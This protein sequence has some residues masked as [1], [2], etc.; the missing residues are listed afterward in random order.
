MRLCSLFAF[1]A[2][3]SIGVA[4]VNTGGILGSVT[5]PSGA[6]VQGVT[7][8][9]T[10]LGTQALR[11]TTTGSDG[12]YDVQLLQVGSYSISAEAQGFKKIVQTGI[13][14]DAGQRLKIDLVLEVGALA[15][16]VAVSGTAPLVNS[17]TSETG[18]VIKNQQVLD[19]PLNGRN[20]SQLIQLEPG[21][22]VTSD[23]RISFS[24]LT[25]DGANITIDGTDAASPDRPSTSDF[26]GQSQQN[27]LS[28]EFIDEFKTTKG[29]FSAELGRAIGGGVNV[30]TKSGTNNF[31]GSLF[32]FLRNQKFDARN[33]FA[34]TKDPLKINQFGMALGGP[35]IRNKLFLFA[36][37][38]APR[39]RRGTQITGNVPTELLR[40]QMLAS[41]PAYKALLDLEPLPNVAG[42]GNT[43]I[44]L[45]R[46]SGLF[47]NDEI[48][49][50][51]RADYHLSTAD[52]FF[53]RYSFLNSSAS[54]PSISPQNPT[55]YPSQDQSGT[56]S[57]AHLFG[58]S[59]FNELRLGWN[60]Q[61]IP[62][63]EAAFTGPQDIGRIANLITTS[64][65]RY[66]RASGGSHTFAD[67]YSW[68]RG[69]QS[70]KFGFED[71]AF[72]YGR[73]S[74]R[75][76]DYQF[77]TVQDLI[78][79][80]FNNVFIT[81]GNP[82]RRFHESQSGFFAQNDWR[83][84]SRLTLNLGLRYEYY[85]PVKED[86]DDLWN[87]VSSPYGPFA[88]KG[89]SVWNPDKNNFGPR[90]GLAWDIG[91]D[92]KNV[93]RTGFGVFY[94]PSTYRELTFLA[95]PPTI[96]YSLTLFRSQ[97][98]S[99]K[100][101]VNILTYD[102][103][104]L[105]TP[106]G[107]DIFDRNARTTYSEQWS[108]NYQRQ[109]LRDLAFQVGY[110]GNRGLK[111]W[112]DHP[113]NQIMPTTGQPLVPSIGLINYQEHSG[114]SNYHSLQTSLTKRFSHGFT[115]N[116]NYTFA[117]GISYS[118]VDSGTGVQASSLV[119][120][121]NCWTC[122]R[123]VYTNNI[124]HNFV[125]DGGWRAPFARWFGVSSGF[126]NKLLDG[127]QTNVI[128]RVRTG[129]PLNILSGLD[130]YG[131]GDNS[132]QRPNYV[133]GPLLLSGYTTSNTHTY[134]SKAAFAQP[135]K[136]QFGNLG[137]DVVNGPGSEIVDMSLFKTTTLTEKLKLQFRW[138]VFNAFNHTNF[139]APSSLTLTNATFGQITT[140]DTPRDIQF[141]LKLLF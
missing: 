133:G 90:F 5:D 77:D 17:Q 134:L 73:V 16:Q 45:N 69:R 52:T 83:V 131:N 85:T 105:P 58:A 41:I 31:H 24:G 126:A 50:T 29:V 60:K 102:F 15:E 80:T 55:I 95:S 11:K 35:I 38:E 3:V 6:V 20:F 9:V 109:V 94:S 70:W 66:L 68:N 44:G 123:M 14:L 78:Q 21:V 99:L 97:N 33:F 18:V 30:I 49:M 93:I 98:P 81:I 137:A 26:G 54:A 4:Q 141:A 43:Q 12:T 112:A 139:L 7:V 82:I 40:S 84:S 63:Q 34:T 59:M 104:N 130:N 107:R 128:V 135:A 67:T 56:A 62:R 1:L 118:G 64:Y 28:I 101:P 75:S 86:G 115:F 113:L 140:A 103:S 88:P 100:Y 13:T 47:S 132:A 120:D 96:P 22:M 122:S 136:G 114:N 36:G 61:D 92:S 8:T 124:T 57:W 25:T 108:F 51:A 111:I 138:E 110:A 121:P 79:G 48:S 89:T 53:V 87:V 117:K 127:W 19:L 74:Y 125:A 65:Q 119:Q 76:P 2:L 46:H 106:V 27:L 42:I 23:G 129:L 37:W 116:A 32:E 91:G 71:R 10:N 39:V 72:H